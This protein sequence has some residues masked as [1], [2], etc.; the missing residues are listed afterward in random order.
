MKTMDERDTIMQVLNTYVDG[1]VKGDASILKSIWDFSDRQSTYLPAEYA[2]VIKGPDNIITY[3]NQNAG[4][5]ST[6][7]IDLRN[8]VIDVLD[9]NYAQVYCAPEWITV[10]ADGTETP[11]YP[12]LSFTMKRNSDR[13]LVIHYHESL[14]YTDS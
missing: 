4:G 7:S 6:A 2:E 1:W 5:F 9:E 3:Y 8:P 11:I 10:D 14:Q 12:R 13:W